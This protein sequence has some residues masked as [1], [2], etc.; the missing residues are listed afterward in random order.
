M[1]T[2]DYKSRVPIYDQIINGIMR[3]KALDVLKAGDKLPSVRNMAISLG[4]NPNTVQKAYAMLEAK[5]VICTVSGKGAFISEDDNAADA[6][7]EAAKE[8]FEASVKS[9]K[10]MGLSPDTLRAV[11]TKIYMEESND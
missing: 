9:A 7:I 5:G 3:L 6:I 8:S 10:A 4:I 2:I 1:I 11:I